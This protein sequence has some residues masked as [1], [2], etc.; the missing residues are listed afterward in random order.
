[1]GQPFLD[2]LTN[3]EEIVGD[4]IINSSLGCNVYEKLSLNATLQKCSF[5]AL[6]CQFFIAFIVFCPH[7]Q[8]VS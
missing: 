7:K 5:S 6:F 8:A 1:M 4:V 2:M 3:K